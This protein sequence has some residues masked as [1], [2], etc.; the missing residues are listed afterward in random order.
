MIKVWALIIIEINPSERSVVEYANTK[1]YK[2]PLPHSVMLKTI[3][4]GLRSIDDLQHR[5]E[6]TIQEIEKILEKEDV[7]VILSEGTY[8][9]PW[10]L[11]KA[12]QRL[13][14]PLVILYAGVLKYETQ[15]YPEDIKKIMANIDDDAKGELRRNLFNSETKLD[16]KDFSPQ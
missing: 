12:S 13:G 5:F 2:I 3:Y 14:A 7:D 1:V 6:P 4:S 16:K 10:C 8:Y 11:Y 9:A 15:H